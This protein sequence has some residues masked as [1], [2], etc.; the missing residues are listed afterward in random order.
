MKTPGRSRLAALPLRATA[1]RGVSMVAV[2][3]LIPLSF[4]LFALVLNQLDVAVRQTRYEDFRLRAELMAASA[5]ARVQAEP[6]IARD[7]QTVRH[8]FDPAQSF[9]IRR[10]AD[11]NGG[12][13]IECRGVVRV[14]HPLTGPA[15]WV[16][17]L[18]LA[19]AAPTA[20]GVP[21]VYRIVGRVRAVE[22]PGASS[23]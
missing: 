16:D 5:V 7:G 6:G 17:T 13:R 18:T 4:G 8:E 11:A 21:P 22:R 14:E 9:E 23:P 2:I 19:E 3:I 20:S 1:R 15:L 10:L 12:A